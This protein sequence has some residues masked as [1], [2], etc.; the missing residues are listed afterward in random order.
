MNLNHKRYKM[1]QNDI[2]AKKFRDLKSIIKGCGISFKDLNNIFQIWFIKPERYRTISNDI[3]RYWTISNEINPMPVLCPKLPIFFSLL[4]KSEMKLYEIFYCCKWNSTKLNSNLQVWT[5]MV[6]NRTL[7]YWT[8]VK[9]VCFI[10]I[11][12]IQYFWL[13]Q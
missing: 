6:V 4:G 1:K 11:D 12:F 5:V 10:F 3:E 7:W 8:N 13:Y 2:K 9:I